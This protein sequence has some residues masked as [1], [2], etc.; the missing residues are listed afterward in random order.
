MNKER[1][2]V[3]GGTYN[4]GR[5]IWTNCNI[6]WTLITFQTIMN[7]ILQNLINTREVLSFID[8]I[9]V[10][11]EE[12]EE[13]DKVVEKV[14]KRLTE[15]DLYVK[16][17]K[18]KWKVREVGFLRVVIR[19]EGIKIDEEKCQKRSVRVVNNELD[20]ILFLFS[21]ILSFKFLFISFILDLDKSVTV[22]KVTVLSH[23]SLSLSHNHVT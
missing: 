8:N 15:N 19:P 14:V 10:E 18:Y 21:F 16:L 13:H 11:M 7:E 23:M 12:E 9:I 2:W 6:L 20:F 3:E 5:V 17:E 1:G 22:T 4:F